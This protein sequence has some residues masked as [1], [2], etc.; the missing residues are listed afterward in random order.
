MC[1]AERA[2]PLGADC[3]VHQAHCGVLLAWVPPEASLACAWAACGFDPFVQPGCSGAL[4]FSHFTSGLVVRTKLALRQAA[5]RPAP[6]ISDT[7]VEHELRP[8]VDRA[9]SSG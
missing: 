4:S 7:G 3:G 2:R 8:R 1:R 5:E 6:S 9:V